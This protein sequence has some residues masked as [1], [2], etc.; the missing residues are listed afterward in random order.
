M[1]LVNTLPFNCHYGKSL[2]PWPEYFDVR[3]TCFNTSHDYNEIFYYMYHSP[4]TGRV[5]TT[6][7]ADDAGAFNGQDQCDLPASGQVSPSPC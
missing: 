2:G 1:G 4:L 3:C 6:P 7:Y 5:L